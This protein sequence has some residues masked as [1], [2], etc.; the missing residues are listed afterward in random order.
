[1]S[2]RSWG[3]AVNIFILATLF[4]P[5]LFTPATMF[6]WHFGK[7]MIFQVLVELALLAQLVRVCWYAVPIKKFGVLEWAIILFFLVHG[8]ATVKSGHGLLGWWGNET[9]AG[10]L[11]TWFHFIIWYWLIRETWRTSREWYIGFSVVAAVASIIAITAFFPQVLPAAWQN[12]DAVRASGLVGNPAFLAAYFVP[13]LSLSGLGLF[14]SKTKGRYFFLATILV[15]LGGIWLSQTRGSWL[16]V[17]AGATIGLSSLLF[18]S[19]SR[20][21]K[22]AAGIAVTSVLILGAGTWVVSRYNPSAFIK[23]PGIERLLTISPASGTARTRLMAWEI[24]LKGIQEKP[25]LG[26]GWEGY[27]VVFNKYY[28]PQFLRFG[29]S[30]TVWDKPH[31]WLLEVGINGGVAGIAAYGAILTSA[32]YIIVRKK[33]IFSADYE[34]A[35][36]LPYVRALLI[37]GLVACF[38]QNLFL[39]ETSFSLWGW[40]LLLAFIGGAFVSDA[41]P[42]GEWY[43]L[44][45]RGEAVKRAFIGVIVVGT[46][47]SVYYGSIIPLRTSYRLARADNERDIQAWATEGKLALDTP[48]F[49]R[50]EVAV[51][52]A[53][54]FTL[55]ARAPNFQLTQKADDSAKLVLA[56]LE[57]AERRWPQVIDFPLWAGQLYQELG[58]TKNDPTLY[59]KAEEELLRAK[60]LS[61]NKQEVLFLL[62]KLY[63]ERQNF[64]KAIATQTIAIEADSEVG[65]SHWL[66][67]VAYA[68][69]GKT[70]DAIRAIETAEAKNFSLTLSQELFLIDLY[71]SQKEYST[72]VARYKKLHEANPDNIQWMVK[73]ATAYALAG[74]KPEALH[75]AQ[76]I[77]SRDSSLSK[78]VNNFIKTYHLESR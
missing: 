64:E 32:V 42:R 28:N 2:D 31:N 54:R 40:W 29:L 62:T 34:D 72:V 14:L 7:T 3:K 22:W 75:L 30:E 41:K 76:D 25:L 77:L 69:Q 52:L 21:F 53:R 8:I 43:F 11:F 78:E 17:I 18:F 26:W 48:L 47:A 45:G 1:M 56:A 16:A 60:A 33:Y 5:L 10:G 71:A 35:G 65:L 36:R 49:W 39:F 20:R 19:Q 63:L 55:L 15:L 59:A 38:V 57:A 61:P 67:G 9:R 4:L 27:R 12:I 44:Q 46:V 24:A 51:L 73:L 37:G 50:G 13:L 70:T 23:M 66:L 74:N 58:E 6:P 68:G